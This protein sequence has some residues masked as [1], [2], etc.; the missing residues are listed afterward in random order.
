MR[1]R[2]DV[3]Q[4]YIFRASQ[5]QGIVNYGACSVFAWDDMAAAANSTVWDTK[6]FAGAAEPGVVDLYETVDDETVL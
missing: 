5:A 3:I 4:V 1:A 2:R 6:R